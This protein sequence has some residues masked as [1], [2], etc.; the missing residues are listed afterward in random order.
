M[1]DTQATCHWRNHGDITPSQVA[2]RNL[3]AVLQILRD[4]GLCRDERLSRYHDD[5]LFWTAGCARRQ[6]AFD[7]GGD[8]SPNNGEVAVFKLE[9]IRAAGQ[10]RGFRAARVR[11]RSN[12]A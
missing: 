6:L 3:A 12:S 10:R 1:D 11:V 2:G 4:M 7:C 5:P 9:N 8:V